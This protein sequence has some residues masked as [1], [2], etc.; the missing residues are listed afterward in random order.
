M[1]SLRLP[2]IWKPWRLWSG[3]PYFFLPNFESSCF[4]AEPGGDTWGAGFLSCLG[5]RASLFDFCCPLDMRVSVHDLGFHPDEYRDDSRSGF[6]RILRTAFPGLIRGFR[7]CRFFC[8]R[9]FTFASVTGR[10]ILDCHNNSPWALG[11]TTPEANPIPFAGNSE[12]IVLVGKIS[13]R[14]QAFR[15]ASSGPLP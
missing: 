1:T 7:V 15:P 13:F 2:R 8:F 14:R 5:L 11:Q 10:L 3:S 4:T 6:V 12:P 9:L